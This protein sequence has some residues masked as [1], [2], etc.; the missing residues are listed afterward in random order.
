MTRTEY[1]TKL[2]EGYQF[3]YK[4]MWQEHF[5]CLA[6]VNDKGS[7][8]FRCTGEEDCDYRVDLFDREA[9]NYLK[10]NND[11]I[12]AEIELQAYEWLL[13]FSFPG[14]NRWGKDQLEYLKKNYKTQHSIPMC[15]VLKK[16]WHAISKKAKSKGYKRKYGTNRTFDELR[17]KAIT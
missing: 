16:S 1:N 14:F 15:L 9:D 2:A 12:K 3:F 10:I 11:I 5:V 8:F 4:V 6:I 17:K 7:H 13:N